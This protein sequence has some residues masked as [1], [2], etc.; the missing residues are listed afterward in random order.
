MINIYLTF[1]W[2]DRNRIGEGFQGVTLRIL[3]QEV[4]KREESETRFTFVQSHGFHIT[5]IV[6]KKWVRG[7][8]E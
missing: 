1:A 7:M 3:G 6:G 8:G 2:V 4:R 5:K